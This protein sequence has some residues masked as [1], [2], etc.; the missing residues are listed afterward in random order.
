MVF[1]PAPRGPWR[2]DRG[3]A[4]ALHGQSTKGAPH[5]AP[6]QAVDAMV[7]WCHGKIHMDI[8]LNHGKYGQNSFD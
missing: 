4:A 7:P 8:I 3:A 5:L 2:L 6:Y 1:P